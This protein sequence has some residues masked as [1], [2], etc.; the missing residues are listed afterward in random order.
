MVLYVL[1]PAMLL[2]FIAFCSACC[3]GVRMGTQHRG[4][5]LGQDGQQ[6]QLKPLPGVMYTGKKHS[7]KQVG[8]WLGWLQL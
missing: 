3:R 2:L 6:L 7:P 1:P 4:G 5:R 8:G